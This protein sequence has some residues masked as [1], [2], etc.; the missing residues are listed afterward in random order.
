MNE[1]QY[2]GR[3]DSDDVDVVAHWI[4]E[5]PEVWADAISPLS[6]DC[7][8]A[9]V[10][11]IVSGS[12]SARL[13]ASAKRRQRKVVAGGALSALLVA[14]GAVGVA[15]IVRS[16][17]PTQ[18]SA[19]VA[20]RDGVDVDANVIVIEPTEDPIGGCGELWATGRFDEPGGAQAVVPALVA[21]VSES[22]VISVFPGDDTTCA[23]LGLVDA[24]PELDATNQAIV[25]LQ[26]RIAEDV[27]LAPC[28]AAEDVAVI[29]QRLVDESGLTGWVVE[30]RP[31]SVGAPCAKAAV[32]ATTRVVQIVKFP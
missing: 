1:R 19:G 26:E 16:G 22:G 23:R 5:H 21:C 4:R 3:D 8:D 25:A 11:E 32:D 9:V 20:C 29:A 7:V 14:G 6:T 10:A 27:N 12:R 30:T 2:D 18:P 24:E 17:Q 28:G 13:Q 15:A 31:D